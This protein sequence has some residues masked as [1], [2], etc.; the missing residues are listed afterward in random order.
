MYINI[1][2]HRYININMNMYVFIH[3]ITLLTLF[4]FLETVREYLRHSAQ[5]GLTPECNGCRN[6]QNENHLCSV[7]PCR[8]R[9]LDGKDTNPLRY[10]RLES[11]DRENVRN[12]HPS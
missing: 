6:H 1:N 11:R 2:I 12:W 7:C 9:I 4:E 8:N 10:P 3:H 5:G